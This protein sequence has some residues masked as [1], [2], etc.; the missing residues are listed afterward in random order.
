MAVIIFKS[1]KGFSLIE[2]LV[3]L[4]LGAVVLMIGVKAL[5]I[6]TSQQKGQAKSLSEASQAQEVS[7]YFKSRFNGT[8][9]FS[10]LRFHVPNTAF[11]SVGPGFYVASSGTNSTSDSLYLVTSVARVFTLEPGTSFVGISGTADTN[12]LFNPA[13]SFT[14]LPVVGDYHAISRIQVTEL[15]K[16]KSIN[17]VLN[18]ANPAGPNLV[19]SFTYVTNSN[20]DASS[21]TYIAP[22]NFQLTFATGDTIHKVEMTKIW[23]NEGA[24]TAQDLSSGTSRVLAPSVSEFTVKFKNR[25]TPPQCPA[26]SDGNTFDHDWSKVNTSAACYEYLTHIE[27]RY[28]SNEKYRSSEFQV[29]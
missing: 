18:P 16:V 10:K 6:L 13:R 1:K 4:I 17:T 2:L 14:P 7:Q 23:I 12:F 9:G 15:A 29:N 20:T 21:P 3:G 22:S 8:K 26:S 28:F 19:S 27:V 25:D 11:N 24:L 5:S